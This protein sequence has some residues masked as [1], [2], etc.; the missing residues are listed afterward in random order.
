MEVLRNT[1]LPLIDRTLPEIAQLFVA[2]RIEAMSDHKD[3]FRL[4]RGH[5]GLVRSLALDL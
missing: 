2:L 1:R 4:V 3:L 5:A